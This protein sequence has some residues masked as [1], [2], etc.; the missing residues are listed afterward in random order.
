MLS[1]AVDYEVYLS[2]PYW[3]P[4]TFKSFYCPHTSIVLNRLL[5]EKLPRSEQSSRYY[6]KC[7]HDHRGDKKS[8]KGPW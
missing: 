2:P 4:R 3:L 6:S 5:K 7:T 8:R 1:T